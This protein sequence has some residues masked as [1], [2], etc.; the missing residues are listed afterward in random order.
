MKVVRGRTLIIESTVY[1]YRPLVANLA[2]ATVQT[3]FKINARDADVD[4][5]YDKTATITDAL[6]GVCQTVLS[7]AETLT[8]TQDKVFVEVVAKLSDGTFIG[9]GITELEVEGN[10]LKTLF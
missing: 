4:A 8:L 7:A 6:G 5:L 2:G 10:V 3:M 1:A 9:S